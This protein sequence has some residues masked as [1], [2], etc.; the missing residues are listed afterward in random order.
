MSEPELITERITAGLPARIESIPNGLLN[1]LGQGVI[2]NSDLVP[3][4]VAQISSGNRPDVDPPLNIHEQVARTK[5]INQ[6]ASNCVAQFL[7]Q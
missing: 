4:I 3:N 7:T 2:K 1:A 6:L 5:H